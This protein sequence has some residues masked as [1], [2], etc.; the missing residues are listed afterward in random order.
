MCY[1]YRGVSIPRRMQETDVLNNQVDLVV[2]IMG[3]LK[4]GAAFSV[5]VRNHLQKTRKTEHEMEFLNT[6]TVNQGRESSAT[7]FFE[8]LQ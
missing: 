1:A 6:Q 8:T 4:A 7:T 2:A 3:I 5:I